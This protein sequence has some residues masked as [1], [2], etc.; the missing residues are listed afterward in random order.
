MGV[1]EV[2]FGGCGGSLCFGG[3]WGGRDLPPALDSLLLC[4]ASLGCSK[5]SQGT[6]Q[7]GDQTLTRVVQALSGLAWAGFGAKYG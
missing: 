2:G 3:C 7:F 6:A 4:F 1:L 5:Q